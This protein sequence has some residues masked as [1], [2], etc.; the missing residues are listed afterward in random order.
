MNYLFAFI[1][2]LLCFGGMALSLIFKKKPLTKGCS[3][4][5]DSCACRAKG[6]DPAECPEEKSQSS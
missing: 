4:D 2:I 6:I 1:V 3:V 5:P